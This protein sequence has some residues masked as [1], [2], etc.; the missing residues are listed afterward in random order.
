MTNREGVIKFHLDYRPGPAPT[1]DEIEELNYW[2]QRLHELQLVGQDS[3]RY[4][5]LVKRLSRTAA[6]H[7]DLDR[8]V[9]LVV[10]DA[11]TQMDRL[12]ELGYGDPVLLN[13]P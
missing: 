11:D 1:A 13:G 10:G 6:V 4:E 2:R 9:W 7:L 12:K 3:E 5:G 8:M